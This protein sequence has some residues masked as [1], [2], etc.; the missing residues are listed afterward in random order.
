MRISADEVREDCSRLYLLLCLFLKF[1]SINIF[2]ILVVKIE[3]IIL[4]FIA[5]SFIYQFEINI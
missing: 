5:M 1:I 4:L 3:D 2:G